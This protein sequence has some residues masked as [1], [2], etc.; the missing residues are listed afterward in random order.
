[1]ETLLR[2]ALPPE[3]NAP[4]LARGALTTL[5]ARLHADLDLEHVQLMVTEL[6]TN[7]LQHAKPAGREWIELSV[8]VDGD[9]LRFE[10]KDPGGGFRA[11]R[12]AYESV[13]ANPEAEAQ[14]PE[15]GYGLTIVST[16]SDRSGVR[17]D[18][19]TVVWF[20][21]DLSAIDSGPA[22]L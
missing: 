19:G 12:E 16:L 15:A 4:G 17:W 14:P 2:L 10:V 5:Q 13:P 21:I 9:R 18:D 20:E 3:A 11:A 22:A 8:K 1:M 7:S 6:I